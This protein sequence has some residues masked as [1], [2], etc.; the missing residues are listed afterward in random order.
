VVKGGPRIEAVVFDLLYTLVHPGT[1][2]GGTGRIGWLAGILGVDPAAVKTRWTAFEPAL[3][4]GR[5]PSA[6]GAASPELAWVRTVAA[7]LGAAVT[8]EDLVRIEADW[9]LTRRQ[10]L[11]DPPASSLA[12]LVSLRERGMRLAVLSNTHALELRTW[13]RS[14]LAPLIDIVALSHE[15]GSCKP[16]PAAY[17]YVLD[18]LQT[19]AASA[20]YVGD[21]SSDEL[22]GARAAGFGMVILADEAP[23]RST[24]DDLPRLRAQAD[25]SVG[26][27]TD[28]V[29]L[30]TRR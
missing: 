21:G 7:E 6:A 26:P 30:V 27:L 13:H 15:I 12:T 9:D 20:A 1:Y 14:P 23:T 10:A 22:A 16:D 19:P 25:A 3:E 8:D 29:A 11:L 24:P 17:G 4:A 5:V 18:R 2:P 28:V